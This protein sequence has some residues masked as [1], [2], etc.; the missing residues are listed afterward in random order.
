MA[1]NVSTVSRLVIDIDGVAVCWY[2]LR[3]SENVLPIKI[4]SNW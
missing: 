2:V 3:A 1:N 4:L